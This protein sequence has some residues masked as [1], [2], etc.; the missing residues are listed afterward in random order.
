MFTSSHSNI[1]M[2]RKSSPAVTIPCNFVS[3]F[4][5]H[6]V[7]KQLF[8]HPPMQSYPITANVYEFAFKYYDVMKK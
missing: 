3:F 1:M 8:F 6:I 5:H 7:V 4:N 2:S